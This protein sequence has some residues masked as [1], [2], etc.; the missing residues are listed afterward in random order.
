MGDTAW[1]RRH[2]LDLQDSLRYLANR[3]RKGFSLIQTVVLAELDGLDTPNANGHRPL[4]ENDPA[5]PHEPYFQHVDAVIAQAARLGLHVGLLPTWGRYWDEPNKWSQPIFTPEK[6]R[7]Y[8]RFLGQRYAGQPIV[9]ILGGDRRVE[10]ERG[11]EVMANLAGGLREGDGG[12]HPIT[13]HPRGPGRSAEE[14]PNEPWIDFHM[15]QTS[16]GARD[17]DTGFFI[18]ADRS[19]H[20]ARPTLDGEPRYEGIPAGF[21]NHGAN[22]ADRFDDFDVRTAAYWALFAGACGHTYGHNSVWQMWQ[23]GRNP[24][25]HAHVP[26]FEAMDHPGAFQ[27]GYLARLFRSRPWSALEPDNSFLRGVPL[28]GPSLVRG[29]RSGDRT[30]AWAYTSRGHPIT[31]DLRALSPRGSIQAS[32]FD[33]RYG[34]IHRIHDAG[35]FGFQTYLPPSQGRGCDWVL[36]LEDEAGAYPAALFPSSPSPMAEDR[37]ERPPNW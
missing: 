3:A 22:P 31:V 11:R 23:V 9:W 16:H 29:L 10:S 21:Y 8:G 33:P 17:H 37:T 36:L 27:M 35:N 5:R 15:C 14:L 20:P 25:I 32:W 13:F 4:L 19:L 26:W 1:D 2:R 12:R 24:I 28:E 34:V 30:L 18:Q 7:L 6:A